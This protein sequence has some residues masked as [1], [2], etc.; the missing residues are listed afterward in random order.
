MNSFIRVLY[1]AYKDTTIPDFKKLI[2]HF[3]SCE[4]HVLILILVIWKMTDRGTTNWE[5]LK[6]KLI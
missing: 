1:R 2:I 5:V 3:N 4:T 6:N